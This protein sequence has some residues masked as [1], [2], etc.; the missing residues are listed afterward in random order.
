MENE[1]VCVV[2]ID[3]D[4]WQLLRTDGDLATTLIGVA[5]E[6][7]VDW[8]EMMAYWPRYATGDAPEFASNLLMEAIEP[9]EAIEALKATDNWIVLDLCQKR[10]LSGPDFDEVTHDACFALS[11]DEDGQQCDPLSIHLPP[12]WE[13][14]E[15]TEVDAILRPRK[16]DV[17]LPFV[18]RE[19]LFGAPLIE[20]FADR[21]LEVAA[22]DDGQAALD[23]GSRGRQN[24]LHL[25][26]VAIHRDWLMTPRDE[27]GGRIPRQMLHGGMDWIDKLTWAQRIRFE[28]DDYPIVAIPKDTQAYLSGPMGREEIAIYF[29]LCRELLEA[30]W[31][32][33]R[34]K[35]ITTEDVADRARHQGLRTELIQFLLGTKET[36][37]SSPFEEGSPP[38]FIFECARRRVPRGDG[39]AIVGMSERQT[40]EHSS[41][42]DCPLCNMI[43]DGLMGVGFSGVDGHHLE[44]D[45]EFAF[46]LCET[47]EEWEE[48]RME[49]SDV[50]GGLDHDDDL[51][52]LDDD[53]AGDE[54]FDDGELDDDEFGSAWPKGVTSDD[55]PGGPSGHLQLAYLLTEIVADLKGLGDNAD[56]IKELNTLFTAFRID[57]TDVSVLAAEQLSQ[58]L[59]AIAAEHPSLLSRVADF[60]SRLAENLRFQSEDEMPF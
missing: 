26:T 14:E 11:I 4:G 33:C 51:D 56:R 5:S 21:V 7:P 45:N 16:S 32:W 20:Y 58:T 2:V 59:E 10:F 57:D 36:W 29:D 6:D 25:L 27:I 60:Q 43:D 38:A 40:A 42:C 50:S 12:W 48:Q 9:T 24:A 41:D 34:D 44:L 1:V 23:G 49:W 35:A 18:D 15:H 17:S 13:L 31:F 55:I 22:S 47:R 8:G 19:F 30:A 54:D 37:L 39:V 53:Q 52:A 46:S 28:Y 3:Q